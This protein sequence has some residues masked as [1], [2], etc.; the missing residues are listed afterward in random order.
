M[1][2]VAKSCKGS[3]LHAVGSGVEPGESVHPVVVGGSEAT[4][5]CGSGAI[6]ELYGDVRGGGFTGILDAIV[7]GVEPHLVAK[8][9]GAGWCAYGH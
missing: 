2:C 3:K 8:C 1:G 6:E 7:V 5:D 9:G 4:R